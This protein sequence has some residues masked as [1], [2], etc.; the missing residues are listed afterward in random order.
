MPVGDLRSEGVQLF[1]VTNAVMVVL[2][3]SAR[4]G[5]I[6]ASAVDDDNREP[7]LALL[8]ALCERNQI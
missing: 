6:K 5:G 7:V 8:H 1:Q 3:S 4:Q 2:R